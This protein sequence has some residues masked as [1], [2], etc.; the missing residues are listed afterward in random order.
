MVESRALGTKWLVVAKRKRKEN[1]PR[2]DRLEE[3]EDVP[4]A[5]R[6]RCTPP[7]KAP[8]A[9]LVGSAH[10][11]ENALQTGAEREEGAVEGPL[12]RLSHAL[13]PATRSLHKRH[14]KPE[15][16]DTVPGSPGR[17]KAGWT[18]S[19]PSGSSLPPEAAAVFPACNQNPPGV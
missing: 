16:I 5:D 9:V 4:L 12:R 3:K 19:F 8:T 7:S 14:G 17:W 18:S 11:T 15:K 1:M 6:T 2:I 13:S 10:A